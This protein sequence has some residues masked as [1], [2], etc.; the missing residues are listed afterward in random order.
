MS[1]CVYVTRKPDPLDPDGPD[2]SLSEWKAVVSAD[3]DLALRDPPDKGPR[4]KTIYAVWES[5]PGGYPAWFG[6]V[7]GSIEVKGMDAVL[8]TKLR[9]FSSKLGARIVSEEGELFT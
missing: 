9:V 6:L 8:L 2:I 4:D 7:D 1:I 3:P 5:F